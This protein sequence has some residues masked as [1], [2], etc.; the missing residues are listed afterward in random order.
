MAERLGGMGAVLSDQLERARR[1]CNEARSAILVEGVS[2]Q[3]AV[4]TLAR[5]RG[6]EL[7]AEGVVVIP[8]AGATNLGRF[9]DLLGPHGCG[10]GLAGLCDQPEAAEFAKALVRGGVSDG[11]DPDDLVA[12]GFF[13]CVRDLEEELTRALGVE[14][15]LSIIES[16]GHLRRFQTYQSQ[17]AHHNKRIEE[18]LWRWLGNHKIRY[19]PLMVEALA[20]D[21]IPPQLDGVLARV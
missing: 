5:R 9:L 21:Q 2:D 4:E 13:V 18:Q 1:A 6:R 8:I 11:L 20:L 19:A 3:R 17:A 10:L 7:E 16:Q 14:A 15:M 12:V